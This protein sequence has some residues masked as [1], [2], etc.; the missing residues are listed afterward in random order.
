MLVQLVMVTY[1][2][3]IRLHHCVHIIRGIPFLLEQTDSEGGGVYLAL[4]SLQVVV[5]LGQKGGDD[6]LV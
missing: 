6:L 5:K 4:L 1:H 2:R 3:D